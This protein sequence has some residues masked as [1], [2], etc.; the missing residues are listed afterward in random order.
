[1]LK[2][3]RFLQGSE[4]VYVF[5]IQKKKLIENKTDR[6]QQNLRNRV[7]FIDSGTKTV[8]VDSS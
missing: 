3:I 8:L 4:N 2:F 5:G 1:M 7:E 6:T